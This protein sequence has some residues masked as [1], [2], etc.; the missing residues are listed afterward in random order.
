LRFL[1]SKSRRADRAAAKAATGAALIR[2]LNPSGRQALSRLIEVREELLE[3]GM[4]TEAYWRM[5]DDFDDPG[6]LAESIVEEVEDAITHFPGKRGGEPDVEGWLA[7]DGRW[8][9]EANLAAAEWLLDGC[10]PAKVNECRA[11][12]VNSFKLGNPIALGSYF[13]DCR[14]AV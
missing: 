7:S 4:D 6:S 9:L 10:E 3:S 8:T 1:T 13:S 5:L 2:P 11:K 12:A 14:E